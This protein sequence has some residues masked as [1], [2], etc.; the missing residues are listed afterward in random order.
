[1]WGCAGVRGRLRE[2]QHILPPLRGQIGISGCLEALG[3]YK[4][5]LAFGAHEVARQ[6]VRQ[7]GSPIHKGDFRTRADALQNVL[8][9]Q[10]TNKLR[11]RTERYPQYIEIVLNQK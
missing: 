4:G 11:I 10:G 7:I 2:L 8:H 1:M 5:L 3:G 6:I 9:R